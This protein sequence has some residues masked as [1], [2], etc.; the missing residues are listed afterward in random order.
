MDML[1]LASSSSV[2]DDDRGE[3]METEITII[4]TNEKRTTMNINNAWLPYA[5][6]IA[7]SPDVTLTAVNEGLRG[8]VEREDELDGATATVAADDADD[9]EDEDGEE[10]GGGGGGKPGAGVGGGW[11][12]RG[13]GPHLKKLDTLV[14]LK[15]KFTEEELGEYLLLAYRLMLSPQLGLRSQVRKREAGREEERRFMTRIH[16]GGRG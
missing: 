3:L 10:E 16:F 14:S 7:A 12:S 15:L 9:D 5:S 4:L 8:V 11:N 6:H 2:P 13:V 1:E